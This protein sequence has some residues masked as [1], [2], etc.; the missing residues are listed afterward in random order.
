M[1]FAAILLWCSSVSAKPCSID[2]IPASMRPGAPSGVCTCPATFSP[3][4][5]ASRTKSF[6]SSTE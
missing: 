3:A 5:A 6:I 1:P 2:Q 4:L